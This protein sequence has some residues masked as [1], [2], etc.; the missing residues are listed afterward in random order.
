[1][2][3]YVIAGICVIAIAA[4][5]ALWLRVSASRAEKAQGRRDLEVESL[6]QGPLPFELDTLPSEFAEDSLTTPGYLTPQESRPPKWAV[7]GR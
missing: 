2:S 3:A 1:M 6:L 4:L 7:S 5:L